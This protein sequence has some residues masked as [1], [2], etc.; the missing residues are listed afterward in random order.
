MSLENLPSLMVNQ[1]KREDGTVEGGVW[2]AADSRQTSV[3]NNEGSGEPQKKRATVKETDG[4][5]KTMKLTEQP[6][7][8]RVTQRDISLHM[9][10]SRR[11]NA[12]EENK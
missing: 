9:C 5:L 10:T 7:Q 2:N 12:I 3:A 6:N 8:V 1:T 4:P 11:K